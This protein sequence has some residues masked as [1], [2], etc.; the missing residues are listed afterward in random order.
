MAFEETT[1]CMNVFIV[2]IP[3]EQERK[4]NMRIR[5]GFEK[6]FCLRSNLSNDNIKSA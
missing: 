1:D 6:Y 4:R 5:N 2:S 3:N